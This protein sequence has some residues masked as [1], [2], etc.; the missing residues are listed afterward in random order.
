MKNPYRIK[1]KNGTF[2]NAGTGENSWFSLEDARKKVNRE[3]GEKIV[4]SDGLN[5]LWEVF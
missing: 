4:E 3:A 1:R 2:L 5:V